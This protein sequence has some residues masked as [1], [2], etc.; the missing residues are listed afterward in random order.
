M[1]NKYQNAKIYKITNT[2][3]DILYIGSTIQKLKRRFAHHKH[4]QKIGVNYPMYEAMRGLGFDKFNIELIENFDC[5]DKKE[6]LNREQEIIDMYDN[7]KL[8]NK[9]RAKRTN[10]E[11]KEYQKK[12]NEKYMTDN[13]NKILE[14][15]EQWGGKKVLCECGREVR[16]DKIKRHTMSKIHLKLIGN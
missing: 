4:K 12:Y 7:I 13:R 15:K 5:N 1:D 14:Y 2:E 6:L 11:K 3:N 10:D 9:F 16:R 8:Y